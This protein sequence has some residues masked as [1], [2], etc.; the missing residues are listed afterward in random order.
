MI[1]FPKRKVKVIL[2]LSETSTIQPINTYLSKHRVVHLYG[3]AGVLERDR[4]VI[5]T[6]F[7]G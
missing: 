7:R 6:S 4:E 1:L 5:G 3:E 2:G